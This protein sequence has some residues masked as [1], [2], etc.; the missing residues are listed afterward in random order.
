MTTQIQPVEKALKA[1]ATTWAIDQVH[2][3]VEFAVKHMMIS[4]VRG[5]FHQFEGTL[6]LDEANPAASSVNATI[7]AASVDTANASRNDVFFNVEN[8]V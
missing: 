6:V 1:A 8:F 5:R 4:T 7:D 3:N 2:S